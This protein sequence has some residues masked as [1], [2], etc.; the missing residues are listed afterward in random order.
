MKGVGTAGGPS[1]RSLVR[2]IEGNDHEEDEDEDGMDWIGMD[3]CKQRRAETAA[4]ALNVRD[5]ESTSLWKLIHTHKVVVD[6]SP[7]LLMTADALSSPLLKLSPSWILTVQQQQQ[8]P[9][10]PFPT[11]SGTNMTTTSTTTTVC[12]HQHEVGRGGGGS[13]ISKCWGRWTTD[14]R[15]K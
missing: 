14:E 11:T 8:Q 2:I 1:W 13:E 3:R 12:R 7:R 5:D 15:R 4:A 9:T 6:A 10:S